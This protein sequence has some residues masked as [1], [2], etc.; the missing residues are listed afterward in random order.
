VGYCYPN[1]LEKTLCKLE[2]YVPLVKKGLNGSKN[3]WGGG[4]LG[5]YPYTR[6]EGI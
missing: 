6:R 3:S 2:I 5:I 4:G 1:R